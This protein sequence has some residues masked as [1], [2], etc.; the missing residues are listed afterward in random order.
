MAC[1]PRAAV[2]SDSYDYRAISLK[3]LQERLKAVDG[4]R[5]SSRDIRQMAGITR[6]E[7]YILDEANQDLVLFGEV[8][9]HYPT[10]RLDDVVVALRNSWL[11][12]ADVKDGT[13][14]Y[15]APYCSIEPDMTVVETL[16]TEGRQISDAAEADT[17]E[18]AVKK[19][20]QYCTSPQ[21]V[22]VKGIPFHSHF[23]AVLVKADYIMKKLAV[24]CDTIEI[25][26]FSSLSDMTL[27][28]AKRDFAIDGEVTLGSSIGNRFW[29]YPGVIRFLEHEGIVT[30]EECE[31]TL[32]TEESFLS[33]SGQI[34]G[35]GASSE[36]A[37]GFSDR[38]TELY[39]DIAEERPVYIDFQNL[40]DILALSKCMK[41]KAPHEAVSLDM[42]CLLGS[43][44]IARTSV[45]EQLP[46]GSMVKHFEEQIEQ[47][48]KRR[49]AN[50]WIPFCGG[51][52][53][54]MDVRAENFEWDES[55]KLARLRERIIKS[56]PEPGALFWSFT[57]WE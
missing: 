11:K 18:E 28:K 44:R 29:F 3:V 34:E 2:A 31:V 26:E 20:Q 46:G 5:V 24:G 30:I 56:R 23:A 49:T 27:E 10:L 50:V 42:T 17:V 39:M 38:F 52:S 32:L 41:L 57:Y 6:I 36:L 9:H 54:N 19:W 14:D 7:G 45:N 40:F 25:D 51:V 15:R 47:D 53:M 37:E 43:Y 21:T 8:E 4:S 48:G 22:I 55:G 12:Y 33:K 16:R 35:E 1:S 13:Y